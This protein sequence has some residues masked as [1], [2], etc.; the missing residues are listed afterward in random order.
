M[1]WSTVELSSC[2]EETEEML[3]LT[4][5]SSERSLRGSLNWSMFFEVWTDVVLD[6]DCRINLYGEAGSRKTKVEEKGRVTETMML[7]D[8]LKCTTG[9]LSETQYYVARCDAPMARRAWDS[10]PC[11]TIRPCTHRWLDDPGPIFNKR[12]Q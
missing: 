5:C 9:G 12:V 8:V 1:R 11:A 2:C 10:S 4:C 6:L 3:L 7:V